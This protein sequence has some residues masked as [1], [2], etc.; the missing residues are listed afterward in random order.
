MDLGVDHAR[1]N[2]K[3]RRL[4]DLAGEPLADRADLDDP[5]VSDAN[6]GECRAVLIDDFVEKFDLACVRPPLAGRCFA[7]C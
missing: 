4:D 3:A 5:A 2:M 1:Q 7:L 6:I